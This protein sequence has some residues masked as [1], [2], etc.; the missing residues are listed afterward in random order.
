MGGLYIHHC[1]GEDYASPTE[2]Y[3]KTIDVYLGIVQ[4]GIDGIIVDSFLWNIIILPKNPTPDY[5]L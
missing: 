2:N 3:N 4:N 5:Q 1:E